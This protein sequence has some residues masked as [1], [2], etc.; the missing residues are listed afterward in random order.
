MGD[1]LSMARTCSREMVAASDVGAGYA[2][3]H[4]AAA[5]AGVS[6]ELVGAVF[7]MVRVLCLMLGVL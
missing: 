1:A 3:C 4:G 2:A 6:F 5:A 7:A